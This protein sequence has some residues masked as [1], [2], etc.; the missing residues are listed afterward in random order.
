MQTVARLSDS[1]SQQDIYGLTSISDGLVQEGEAGSTLGSSRG[2]LYPPILLLLL[3]ADGHT[4]SVGLDSE[5]LG[6][7][8][9]MSLHQNVL[10]G[11]C[12][13]NI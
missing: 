5:G 8:V 11:S 10:S 12:K 1:T 6:L 3:R 7:D 9:T 4:I 13:K 2:A